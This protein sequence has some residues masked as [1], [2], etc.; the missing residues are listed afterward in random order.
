MLVSANAQTFRFISGNFYGSQGNTIVSYSASGT[1]LG[2]LPLPWANELR[3]LAF[4]PDGLLYAVS[5]NGDGFNVYALDASGQ[6]HQT[7]PYPAWIG[8]NISWGKIA[9]DH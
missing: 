5:T 2:T 6:V 4:G 8:G 7:Y 1:Q 9:F 3:G